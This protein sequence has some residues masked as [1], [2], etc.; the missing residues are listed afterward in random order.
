MPVEPMQIR[1]APARTYLV[2]EAAASSTSGFPLDT[3]LSESERITR[4]AAIWHQKPTD[5]HSPLTLYLRRLTQDERREEL[6]YLLRYFQKVYS[7]ERLR[8]SISLCEDFEKFLIYLWAH[9]P[10]VEQFVNMQFFNGGHLEEGKND[11]STLTDD[12]M[13]KVIEYY[14]K[15]GKLA[16]EVV[17][18]PSFENLFETLLVFQEQSDGSR[19]YCV[20]RN[21]ITDYEDT[22]RFHR[23]ALVAYK[24]HGKINLI[25][26]D[27]L[28]IKYSPALDMLV[29]F[30]K[31]PLQPRY[32][33]LVQSLIGELHII[34]TKRQ[35]DCF[36]CAS[37]AV[38]DLIWFCQNNV[39]NLSITSDP[40]SV[41]YLTD[42]RKAIPAIR[43]IGHEC[44]EKMM[45]S[46][47][48]VD[49]SS[50]E[51]RRK[52]GSHVRSVVL[53]NHISRRNLLAQDR[54]MKMFSV[55]IEHVLSQ[56]NWS[57]C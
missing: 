53:Q 28:G 27:S 16:K 24:E 38:K 26:S 37:F 20:I 41:G 14:Q 6:S 50:T 23:L 12:G 3:S 22:K 2:A 11:I 44:D 21:N 32:V 55:V 54:T 1:V 47:Q 10:S 9:Y 49:V 46:S 33:K 31:T 17:Q 36:T 5:R 7:G 48:Y 57:M 45:R 4:I 40:E 39:E 35:K 51:V 8:E 13:T 30:L 18:C 43:C 56:S 15:K 29:Q 19:L 25:L 34:T 52:L 42:I